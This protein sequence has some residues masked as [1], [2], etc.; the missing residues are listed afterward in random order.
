[1]E[2]NEKGISP[3]LIVLLVIVG[4][5]LVA[6]CTW[7][8]VNYFKGKENSSIYDSQT[9]DNHESEVIHNSDEFILDRWNIEYSGNIIK[10]PYTKYLKSNELISKIKA[11][12]SE[13]KGYSFEYSNGLLTVAVT[14]VFYGI[15]ENST[16]KYKF[17]GINENAKKVLIADCCCGGC[18][19][20]ALTENGNLY[21]G[22]FSEEE[23]KE[24]SLSK[25]KE[26]ISTI[27]TK[28]GGELYFLDNSGDYY[29]KAY[30][31][32]NEKEIYKKINREQLFKYKPFEGSDMYLDLNNIK[33]NELYYNN[34]IIDSIISYDESPVT[35]S[36]VVVIDKDKYG[37]IFEDGELKEITDK[38]IVNITTKEEKDEWGVINGTAIIEIE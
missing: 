6:F 7:Y 25:E 23:E 4:I 5:S 18:S 1:M 32:V 36:L 22:S 10:I 38:R 27:K 31:E 8:G 14:E 11:E 35:E 17:T 19:L 30:D 28:E 24:I 21:Y 20:Y 13:V 37:Y 12:V 3:V 29:V 16:Y 26:N 2:K 34:I 15:D 9:I 33:N